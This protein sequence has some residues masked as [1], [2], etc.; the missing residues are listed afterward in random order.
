MQA[1]NL[2]SRTRPYHLDENKY[3]NK[4]KIDIYDGLASSLTKKL[5]SPNPIP[6]ECH[7][8]INCDVI[9]ILLH[10]ILEIAYAKY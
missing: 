7:A 2:C 4:E 1:F 5:R 3:N 9:A 8:P 6:T 10:A